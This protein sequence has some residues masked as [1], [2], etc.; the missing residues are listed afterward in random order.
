MRKM[1]DFRGSPPQ[2]LLKKNQG[3]QEHSSGG[4][5]PNSR[6]YVFRGR[7]PRILQG[8]FHQKG[9]Q[10]ARLQHVGR[11][12]LALWVKAQKPGISALSVATWKT[13]PGAAEP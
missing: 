8:S 11:R 2:S 10:Q 1:L 3:C 12:L 6:V 5:A 9:A 13:N 4:S 7:S